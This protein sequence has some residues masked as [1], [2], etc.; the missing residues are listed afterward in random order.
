MA[1]NDREPEMM[2]VTRQG[3]PFAHG[4]LVR[5]ARLLLEP[6]LLAGI[7]LVGAVVINQSAVHWRPNI[8]DDPMFAYYG[9]C[10]SEGARPY[11][12]VWDNK[13]PGIWWLNAAAIRLCGPGVGSELLPGSLAV[14]TTLLAFVGI[15]RTV[16]H[17][18]LL[19][20]AALAGAVL[21]TELRFECGGNRTE[22]YVIAC[23]TLAIFAYVRWLRRRR[24][25][26][27]LL[28]GLAAGA[29]PLFK[30]SGIAVG[31]ACAAHMAWVQWRAS[32]NH[33][34]MA[35]A[36]GGHAFRR[37]GARS[38]WRAWLIAAGGLAVV[39]LI[40]ASVLASQGALAEAAF[41]VGRFN[42][43]YFEIGDATWLR[44]DHALQI[45]QP[46]IS[47]FVGLLLI[48]AAGLACGL[49][50]F[51]AR[52]WRKSVP[53][54]SLGR[55]RPSPRRGVGLI[56]LWFVL[57]AYLAC[58]GPGRRGHHMMPALPAL[59][60]LVLYPLHLIVAR[61]GLRAC[62]TASPGAAAAVVVWTFV[63]G[64]LATGSVAA[65]TSCWQTK[66][67]W[68]AL[69][70]S[71][72]ASYEVR[73]AEI[74]RL[75]D[76]GD[77]IYIWGWSPETYRFACRRPASRFATLEKC[78][79]VGEHARFNLDGAMAD[80]RRHPP[81]LFGISI[82]DYAG[83]TAPPVG[84]FAAWLEGQYELSSTVEGMH[85]L[86]RRCRGALVIP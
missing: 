60:L 76:P 74:R 8:V 79:Q 22:T 71:Q 43:A 55:Q 85:I 11:V 4:G 30:Q 78:G 70:R 13:P 77:T 10:V 28:A 62:L 3:R 29:A 56:V 67:H 6:P 39:P 44:V 2:D 20:P 58:V 31:L 32:R 25:P 24:W 41:A 38:G 7:L 27:L 40:S 82:P 15:A 48:A 36:L 57:A 75:S 52:R 42:R 49:A 47:S 64:T 81:R 18:S 19:V 14:L 45:Y 80:I 53:R 17:R 1:T 21:L 66:P 68:Y 33:G 86:V 61:R 50:G 73:A 51:I 16:F 65:A 35:A 23:E 83:M 63:L 34:G 12:D 26:C 46:V 54:I 69:D 5:L 37:R 59:G 84:D 9:W 72:P